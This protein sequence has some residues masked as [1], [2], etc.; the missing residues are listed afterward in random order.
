MGYTIVLVI[1]CTVVFY[2]I[3]DV[4]KAIKAMSLKEK[5]IILTLFLLLLL[6]S[7]G[8]SIMGLLCIVALVQSSVLLIVILYNF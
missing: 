1:V 3:E 8:K 4:L 6:A 2:I 7:F 5:I